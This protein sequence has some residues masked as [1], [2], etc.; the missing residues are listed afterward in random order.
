MCENI[1]VP[2]L[3]N[4]QPRQSLLPADS[5]FFLSFSIYM[6]CLALAFEH[7]RQVYIV[8]SGLNDAKWEK[9]REIWYLSHFQAAKKAQP[10]LFQCAA[11]PELS[12]LALNESYK[13]IVAQRRAQSSLCQRT[14]HRSYDSACLFYQRTP[15]SH[16][17]DQLYF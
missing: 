14:M 2:P 7:Y 3:G 10:S 8:H 13:F 5:I 11:S 17:R 15:D 1:R 9:K 6:Y 12:L 4:E 16:L